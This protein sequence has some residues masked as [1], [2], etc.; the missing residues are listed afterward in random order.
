MYRSV[1]FKIAIQFKRAIGFEMFVDKT[2][3]RCIELLSLCFGFDVKIYI[4]RGNSDCTG[5][6]YGTQTHFLKGDIGHFVMKLDICL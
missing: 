3:K 6:Q 4:V 1:S 5:C 2:I